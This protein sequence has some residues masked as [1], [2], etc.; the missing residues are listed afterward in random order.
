MC[1]VV[2]QRSGVTVCST[3]CNAEQFA[4]CVNIFEH[5]SHYH[6][7]DLLQVALL[8]L[9]LCPRGG[10]LGLVGLDRAEL[11]SPGGERSGSGALRHPPHPGVF[12]GGYP[13]AVGEADSGPAE[14]RQPQ[15]AARRLD[16][17]IQPVCPGVHAVGVT[18]EDGRVRSAAWTPHAEV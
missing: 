5:F 15:Q 3:W 18:D 4:G 12:F 14:L 1:A 10:V 9:P 11:Q 6:G 16:V 7:L 2:F 17:L 13:L 8:H